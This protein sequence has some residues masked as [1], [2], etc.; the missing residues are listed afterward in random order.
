MWK[1]G[2]DQGQRECK[3]RPRWIKPGAKLSIVVDELQ[4]FMKVVC[5]VPER[6]T[7]RNKMAGLLRA[8]AVAF[9]GLGRMGS[10]MARN[11]LSKSRELSAFVVCDHSSDAVNSFV[12]SLANPQPKVIVTETPGEYGCISIERYLY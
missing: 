2:K 12:T 8:K 1:R 7:T 9:I 4:T 3:P 5:V 6:Q 10:E 11:L